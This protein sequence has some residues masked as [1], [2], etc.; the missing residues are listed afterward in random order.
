M[1]IQNVQK[2]HHRARLNLS[3]LNNE[4]ATPLAVPLC[5]L[6][7]SISGDQNLKLH[8]I[9][10]ERIEAMTSDFSCFILPT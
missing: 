9:T 7:Q 2:E 8:F 3:H 1:V 4:T 5:C 6:I 10:I